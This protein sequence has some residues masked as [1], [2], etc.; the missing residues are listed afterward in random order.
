MA[1]AVTGQVPEGGIESE[2]TGYSPPDKGETFV[3]IIDGQFGFHKDDSTFALG[4]YDRITRFSRQGYLVKIEDKCGLTD[5]KGTL[6]IP[7][8]YDFIYKRI[9]GF[10]TVKKDGKEGLINYNGEIIFPCEYD[11][12]K[13]SDKKYILLIKAGKMGLYSKTGIEILPMKYDFIEPFNVSVLSS[14][15]YL[16]KENN[17]TGI[18]TSRSIIVPSK[19]DEVYESNGFFVVSS[20]DF[21]GLYNIDGQVLLPTVY[22]RI[23]HTVNR[24]SNIMIVE[25]DQDLG[26]IEIEGKQ[27]LMGELRTIRYIQ[28]SEKLNS[29]YTPNRFKLYLSV[30][31]KN[32]KWGVF[33]EY[34]SALK[35]P[36]IYD[37]IVQK[38]DLPTATYFIVQKD[39]KMG[40]VNSSNDILIPFDYE[41]LKF[42]FMRPP[43]TETESD[44][45][46]VAKTKNNYGLI[47]LANKILI[48]FEY[49]CLS[50]ISLG[51]I[52]KAKTKAGYA[53]I[54]SKNEIINAGPF[55]QVGDFD[56]G[57]A[58][59]FKD[60]EM[61]QINESCQLISE[62]KP[63]RYH[64]GFRSF[65]ALK[66]ALINSLNS[67][68]EELLLDFAQKITP[69]KHIL[70]LFSKIT[71]TYAYVEYLSPSTLSKRYY[72]VL[73]E[74]KKR[75]SETEYDQN[76]LI[77]IE[78]YTVFE[79][80]VFTNQRTEETTFGMRELEWILRDAVRM[81]G[82]WV[83][84]FFL[85]HSF[86]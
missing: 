16:V 60:D 72:E 69:S 74:A 33:E 58:L 66:L 1:F 52:Y 83:S 75:W 27:H 30:Q 17:L 68:D 81:D 12:I 19:F 11:K 25:K 31:G 61:R 23:Y 10:V 13:L 15:H 42:N 79:G 32:D 46:I 38:L 82:F 8:E 51:D 80:R 55:D 36:L 47:D 29:P 3:T 86:K 39:K 26:I 84:T 71:H 43:F 5:N 50:R 37:A 64:E 85:K 48:P 41:E 4:V 49:D 65:E 54:N 57:V 28:N 18:V 2:V 9:T 44:V 73:L 20:G 21:V 76:K 45:T 62:A 40:V 6:I 24:R 35:I 59:T 34:N 63:M 67:K 78:D 22:D 53:L 56:K 77:A 14:S 70:F 7:V